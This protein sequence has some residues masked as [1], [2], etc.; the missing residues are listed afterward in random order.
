[1]A[2]ATS[3]ITR[4]AWREYFDKLSRELGTTKATVEIEASDLGAQVQAEGLVLSGISYDD[5]D[6]VLV[7][8]LSPG[9]PGEVLEHIVSAPR[10][11]LLDTAAGVIPGAVDVED[12]E[13]ARTLLRLRP[14][15]ALAAE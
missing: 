12:A 10:R 5:R 8:G 4:D 7:I 9:G 14:A 2:D 1:M 15:P 3:E 11:I 13:G 6:D